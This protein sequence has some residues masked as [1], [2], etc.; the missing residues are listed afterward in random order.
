M[1]KYKRECDER[2]RRDVEAEV[3]RVRELEV[4]RVRME[5]AA[6]YR[7]SIND[8]QS[9][10]DALHQDK[11]KELKLREQEVLSR[12]KDKERSVEQAAFEH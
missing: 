12:C 1:L 4:S 8:F 5:E 9:E 3:S 7:K 2:V 11:I 6:K 10:L